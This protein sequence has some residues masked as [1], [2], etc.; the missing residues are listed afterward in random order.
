MLCTRVIPCLLLRNTG[1]VKT[2]RFTNPTYIGDAVNAVKIFNDKEVDEIIVLDILAHKKK[3]SIQWKL[4][5]QIASECFM[6]MCYGGGITQL[7]EI[8]RL[9]QIGMEK[10]SINTALVENPSVIEKA[11]SHFGSQSIVAAIDVKKSIW[12]NYSVFTNGGSKKAPVELIQHVKHLEK[13]GV[14]ELLINSIDCDGM[15]K[16]YDLKLIRAVSKEVRIPVIACGGA[17][18]ISDLAAAIRQGA[19]AVAAGSMFV[20]HGPHRAVLINFPN[21]R[22]LDAAFSEKGSAN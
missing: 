9:F 3:G 14:G 15:Q 21:R 4:I 18:G 6:P 11:I 8:K 20:F 17:G 12:G 10:V 19:S 2:V 13:M 1:L 22:E 5:E 7:E 16:G